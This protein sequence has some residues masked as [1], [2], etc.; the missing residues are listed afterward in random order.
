MPSRHVAL[1]FVLDCLFAGAAMVKLEPELFRSGSD[2]KI[3]ARVRIRQVAVA[4]WRYWAYGSI[5]LRA[6][7]VRVLV[8]LLL[9]HK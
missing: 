9:V 1:C 2:W 8:S 3:R 7:L 6:C 4:G 5:W